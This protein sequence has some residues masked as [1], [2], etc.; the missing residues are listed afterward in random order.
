MRRFVYTLLLTI[1]GLFSPFVGAEEHGA[2]GNGDRKLVLTVDETLV[3][4]GEDVNFTAMLMPKEKDVTIIFKRLDTGAE[5]GRDDTDG[6]GKAERPN[7]SQDKPIIIEFQAET[8]DGLMSNKVT[9]EWVECAI[10]A[11]IPSTPCLSSRSPRKGI[12]IPP[13]EFVSKET[14]KNFAAGKSLVL[15]EGSTKAIDLE[16]INAFDTP[17]W[18]VKRDV[19]SADSPE[20]DNPGLRMAPF[21]AQE[22][23]ITSKAKM[24]ALSLDAVGSFSVVHFDDKDA[25]GK[26][27]DEK[28][29]G[30]YLNVIVVR[31]QLSSKQTVKTET[32]A[33]QQSAT[34]TA[35][36]GTI[37]LDGKRSTEL[38]RV[39]RIRNGGTTLN[40]VG[41]LM[42]AQVDII[43]G[44]K[45]GRRGVDRVV[46]GWLNNLLRL[47][48]QGTYAGKKLVVARMSEVDIDP[49][50]TDFSITDAY[51]KQF[52]AIRPPV[53]AATPLLDTTRDD[54]GTGGSTIFLK[55][56]FETDKNDLT[57]G[58]QRK[59][60]AVDSPN[61]FLP[62]RHPKFTGNRLE[63]ITYELDFQAWLVAFA[64]NNKAEPSEP[65]ASLYVTVQQV[66]W[67]TVA[68]FDIA[69]PDGDPPNND[70]KVTAKAQNTIATGKIVNHSPAIPLEKVNAESCP[71][72]V[73]QRTGI[74]DATK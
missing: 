21:P 67:N 11:T 39:I 49:S 13:R 51:L 40:T 3:A 34:P 9:V 47:N 33:S 63:V 22:L 50:R 31:V 26:F 60:F 29:P 44:G 74:F 17:A 15:I 25:D 65:G 5:I 8:E 43:G 59:V 38:F 35:Q 55:N 70:P 27:D 64:G 6:A 45:G 58:Q 32:R 14:S 1:T 16:G 19:Q 10:R 36:A 72:S 24:A 20:G 54:P 57:L 7:F 46:L 68:N 18:V 53:N 2:I 56:T 69:W 62:L 12:K 52:P 28:E 42:Q 66:P 41:I 30:C 48:I 37:L 4:V 23:S 61:V 73:K 71:P